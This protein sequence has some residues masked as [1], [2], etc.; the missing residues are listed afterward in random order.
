MERIIPIEVFGGPIEKRGVQAVTPS[1]R[2]SIITH[3]DER[4][5]EGKRSSY[6][7]EEE[8]D[9]GDTEGHDSGGQESP[10]SFGNCQVKLH[11]QI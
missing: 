4:V 5:A 8:D 1:T 11:A 2:S 9:E 7:V 10:N 6:L 3:H